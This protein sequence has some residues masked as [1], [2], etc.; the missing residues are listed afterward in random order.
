M[1]WGHAI[2]FWD[3]WGVRAMI[4][5]A[6]LGFFALAVSL[7]SSFVLYR[8]AGAAQSELETKAGTL[9]LALKAQERLT[10][11]A[12][13]ETARLKAEMAWRVLPPELST[14]LEESLSEAPGSV[15]IQFVA[16]DPESQAFAIQLAKIFERA[17]WKVAMNALSF[18]GAV[19]FGIWIPDPPNQDA[20]S[21]RRIFADLQIGYSTANLP[22]AGMGLGSTIPGAAIL[23]V[24]SKAP[25]Q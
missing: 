3:V 17:K 7:F 23:F 8:V 13:L 15:N 12:Q 21:I 16:A 5:G 1:L 11:D 25:P 6:I 20:L 22:P 14:R 4:A 19:I 2:H 24:G 9:N 18:S 10:A